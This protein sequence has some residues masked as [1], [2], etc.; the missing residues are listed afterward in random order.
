MQYKMTGKYF[1]HSNLPKNVAQCQLASS[2]M[3]KR[4]S[5]YENSACHQHV[6]SRLLLPPISSDGNWRLSVSNV[7]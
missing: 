5:F 7:C 3:Q 6:T 1:L 4:Q 2:E